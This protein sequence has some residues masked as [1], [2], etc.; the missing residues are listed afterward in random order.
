[1]EE[2]FGERNAKYS[3]LEA[4]LEGTV[5]KKLMDI[6][7]GMVC[8]LPH[9]RADKKALICYYHQQHAE[10]VLLLSFLRRKRCADG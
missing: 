2:C 3:Q 6:V 7:Q 5:G 8:L 4:K 10:Y 9:Y 1:M